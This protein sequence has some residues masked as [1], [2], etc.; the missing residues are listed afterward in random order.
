MVLYEIAAFYFLFTCT[1][2]DS[3]FRDEN[4]EN[5]DPV[6]YFFVFFTV[7]YILWT[8]CDVEIP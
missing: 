5:K 7:F 6:L 4:P 1:N 8:E 2:F 3:L